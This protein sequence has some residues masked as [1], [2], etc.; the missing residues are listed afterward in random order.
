MH[1]LI[2]TN[3]S[4]RVLHTGTFSDLPQNLGTAC[5]ILLNARGPTFTL[6]T[7]SSSLLA[8]PTR[9]TPGSG[10]FPPVRT[11]SCCSLLG[12][13]SGTVVGHP[14]LQLALPEHQ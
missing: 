12:L 2:D 10:K 6:S 1:P 11:P 13:D 3:A 8:S 9:T 14:L 4:K 5:L 7:N